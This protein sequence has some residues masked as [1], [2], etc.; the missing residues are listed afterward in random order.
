MLSESDLHATLSRLY[1]QQQLQD[2]FSTA[3]LGRVLSPLARCQAVNGI[4]KNRRMTIAGAFDPLPIPGSSAKGTATTTGEFML[5][6]ACSVRIL[7][8]F[9]LYGW[10]G[11]DFKAYLLGK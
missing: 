8:F 11:N 4:I 10:Q 7:E 5:S 3:S 6:H 2:N 9:W 1:Q